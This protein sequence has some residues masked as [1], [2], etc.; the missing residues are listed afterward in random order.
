MHGVSFGFSASRLWVV[1][2]AS[3]GRSGDLDSFWAFYAGVEG[4]QRH[5][6]GP[7]VYEEVGG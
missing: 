3:G 5:L 2:D 1:G 7:S 4:F 6:G